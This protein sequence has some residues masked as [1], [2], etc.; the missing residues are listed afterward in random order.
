MG[1]SD[2]SAL[3]RPVRRKPEEKETYLE[4]SQLVDDGGQALE[5]GDDDAALVDQV[6]FP[7][8]QDVAHVGH[9]EPRLQKQTRLVPQVVEVVVQRCHISYQCGSNVT[10]APSSNV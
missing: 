1:A 3:R 2:P 9:L 4:E 8:E 10:D 7:H 6:R 5:N